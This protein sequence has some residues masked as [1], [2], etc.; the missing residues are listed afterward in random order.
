MIEKL[1]LK[2][3]TGFMPQT[4]K[5]NQDAYVVQRDLAGVKGLTALGVLD[6]HGVNGH[7]VSNFCKNALPSILSHLIDGASVNDLVYV[8]G[9]I[10]NRN[11]HYS[12]QL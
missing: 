2:S 5:V 7:L 8:G 10:V 12:K 4:R 9:K 1:G 11:K 3:R 6:G